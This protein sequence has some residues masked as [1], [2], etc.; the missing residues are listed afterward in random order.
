MG[1]ARCGRLGYNVS[2]LNLRRRQLRRFERV[3]KLCALYSANCWA[4]MTYFNSHNPARQSAPG[5]DP[6]VLSFQVS[7]EQAQQS[8]HNL[9]SASSYADLK[10]L[11]GVQ[12]P[13]MQAP[14]PNRN[15]RKSNQ[16]SEHIKHR[17]T[18]SGCYTCRSRRVK[19]CLIYHLAP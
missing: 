19:V 14:K 7:Q 13:M 16:G 9:S 5:F 11:F 1:R 17:R 4:D 15:R 2:T 3:L 8:L 6:T 10:Y 12:D 18:R